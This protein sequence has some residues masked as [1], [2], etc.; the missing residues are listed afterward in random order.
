MA[1]D[2]QD[3]AS[4]ILATLDVEPLLENTA[5]DYAPRPG[6]RPPTK[7]ERRGIRL[8]HNVWDIVFRRR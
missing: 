2:W 4:A 8:G 3:Y 5:R 1:T 6:Y 7:F